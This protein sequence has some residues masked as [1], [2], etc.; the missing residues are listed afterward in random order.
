MKHNMSNQPIIGISI[1][2]VYFTKIVY[3]KI[4]IF[5]QTMKKK[6]VHVYLYLKKGLIKSLDVTKW[7]D[8]KKLLTREHIDRMHDEIVQNDNFPE[9]L[10]FPAPKL[11]L[12]TSA[13]RVPAK[14]SRPKGS[15]P[16]QKKKK[17]SGQFSGSKP[18]GLSPRLWALL[19]LGKPWTSPKGP[20]GTECGR[21]VYRNG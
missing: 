7:I 16:K 17:K 14:E 5:V 21:F 4:M 12:V 2:I 1:I 11:G 9:K 10:Q 13:Q 3:L 20:F 18:E 19:N 8:C 15:R 6:C